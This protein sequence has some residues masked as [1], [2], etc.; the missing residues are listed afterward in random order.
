[1]RTTRVAQ[2]DQDLPVI[3]Q[4]TWTMGERR[5][6]RTREVDALRLGVELGMTMIDTAEYYA[7]GG[8][9]RIVADAI[10]DIRPRVFLVDKVW[11]HRP[12]LEATRRAAIESLDRTGAGYF[13]LLLVHWPTPRVRTHLSALSQLRAEGLVRYI[14]VSNF[15]ARWLAEAEGPVA[16]NQLPYNLADRRVEAGLLAELQAR[17]VLVMAYSP[18][19]HGRLM[20][21]DRRRVLDE[22]GAMQ[23]I[24]GAQAA[25]AW[26]VR[27]PGVAAIPK[28][29][30]PEHVRANAAAGAIT[31]DAAQL[32]RLEQMFPA[33]RRPYRTD[34]PAWSP[35]FRLAYDWERRRRA[36]AQ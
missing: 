1:V 34:L 2:I 16:A 17:G 13:D 6:L 20:R 26:T 19:G 7:A 32:S 10:R 21:Q 27:H 35:L 31:L 22:V 3:G 11:P 12:T 14:G 24:S 28:A 33:S 5:E 30:S 15:S 23:G 29:V 4:G 8:A 9:E 36:G 18:L 25:L